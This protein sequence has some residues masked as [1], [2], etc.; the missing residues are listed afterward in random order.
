[1][2]QACFF[3]LDGTL[4]RAFPEGDTTRG[5]RT[6]D[7]V[8]ILPGTKESLDRLFDAGYAL[9]V[10]TNQPGLARGDLDPLEHAGVRLMIRVELPVRKI[11]TCPHDGD[12]CA[13]RKPRPGLII[14]AAVEYELDLARCWMIGDR[15]SDREAAIR[16]GI[17]QAQTIKLETNQGIKEAVDAILAFAK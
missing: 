11:Y 8:E 17:P 3:D 6:R 9:L 7:E 4:V 5:P 2:N 15:E 16:A 12:W 10:V 14:G 13:C 1:M